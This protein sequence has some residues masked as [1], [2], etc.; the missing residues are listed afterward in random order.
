MDLHLSKNSAA[1]DMIHRLQ[2]ELMGLSEV[3]RDSVDKVRVDAMFGLDFRPEDSVRSEPIE[4]RVLEGNEA[5]EAAFEALTSIW[6]KMGQHPRETLRV[7][8]A[9]ALP[10]LAIEKILQTNATRTELV[11]LIGAIEKT[12]DRRNVWGRFKGRG[13]G[14]VPK[15][16]LRLTTVLTDPLNINFYWDDTGSSGARKMAGDL[17][18][19]WK[20]LLVQYRDKQVTVHHTSEASAENALLYGIDKLSTLDPGSRLPF[21]D[22]FN[23]ISAHALETVRPRQNRSLRLFRSFTN[24]DRQRRRSNPSPVTNQKPR[25]RKRQGWHCS[26]RCL[27]SRP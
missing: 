22:W 3:L 9:I 25:T 27:I 18:A 24:G 19:E 12:N 11:R 2:S 4:V 14:I 15:Q 1:I 6:V 10:R 21:A 17:L 26:K 7:P 20:E 13:N 16:A 5:V 8:G 23:R